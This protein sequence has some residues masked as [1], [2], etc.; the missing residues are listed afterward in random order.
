M[1]ASIVAAQQV[2]PQNNTML[3]MI[4]QNAQA[5]QKLVEAIQSSA[6]GGR[7]QNVDLTI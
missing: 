1:T 3:S 6:S 5:E 7:G 4:K 2:T